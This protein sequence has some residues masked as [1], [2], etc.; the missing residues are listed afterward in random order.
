MIA[1]LSSPL[2]GALTAATHIA[3]RRLPD[4]DA[5]A[6]ALASIFKSCASSCARKAGALTLA[7]GAIN[8]ASSTRQPVS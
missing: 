8:R 2:D 3:S 7:K 6:L 1:S 4:N 5:R